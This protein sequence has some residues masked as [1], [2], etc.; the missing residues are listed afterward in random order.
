[1]I[2]S[3]ITALDDVISVTLEKAVTGAWASW[4][5]RF[6]RA[7]VTEPCRTEPRSPAISLTKSDRIDG[8]Y[9]GLSPSLM[10][11]IEPSYLAHHE[12]EWPWLNLVARSPTELVI[13]D[14]YNGVA[15]YA[16]IQQAINSN[17]T[18]SFY[19]EKVSHAWLCI[20]SNCP[21]FG[22]LNFWTHCMIDLVFLSLSTQKY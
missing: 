4:H 22:D 10:S 18:S 11:M 14:H 3:L 16:S 12:T 9:P 21:H 6:S 20:E 8:S 15:W 13:P 7:T 1:M 17:L 5:I 19:S 2:I